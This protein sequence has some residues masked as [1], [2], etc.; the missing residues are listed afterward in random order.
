VAHLLDEHAATMQKNTVLS[1]LLRPARP[2]E[3]EIGYLQP[4]VHGFHR[5]LARV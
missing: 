3:G 2:V 5:W 1:I 4:K